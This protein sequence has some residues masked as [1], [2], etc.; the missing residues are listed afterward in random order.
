M[1]LNSARPYKGLGFREVE[2]EQHGTA[3]KI[4]EFPVVRA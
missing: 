1:D 2:G 3:Y 4:T